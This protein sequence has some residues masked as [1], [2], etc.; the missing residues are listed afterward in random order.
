[1]CVASSTLRTM[2]CTAVAAASGSSRK[3]LTAAAYC[4]PRTFCRSF[5]GTLT[6]S[7]RLPAENMKWTSKESGRLPFARTAQGTATTPPW[8]S[9]TL[10]WAKS[11]ASKEPTLVPVRSATRRKEALSCGEMG[12]MCTTTLSWGPKR[13]AVS[14]GARTL[15]PTRKRA[16]SA[17]SPIFWVATPISARRRR[18]RLTFRLRSGLPSS[19]RIT[20]MFSGSAS[21]GGV[22]VIFSPL[23]TL[24]ARSASHAFS[25]SSSLAIA[26]RSAL[27]LA[28]LTSSHLAF[29]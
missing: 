20:L 1:M 9:E 22:V 25:S 17:S 13:S 11:P 23:A 4:L 18:F 10:A 26:S 19:L 14:S 12:S 6:M 5:A 24:A 29:R 16:P 21:G 27:S 8:P 2:R 7:C 3:A 28:A 15:L